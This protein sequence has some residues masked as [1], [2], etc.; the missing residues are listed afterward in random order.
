MKLVLAGAEVNSGI[1]LGICAELV[2]LAG[3]NCVHAD[4]CEGCD[5]QAGQHHVHAA[6]GKGDA[7]DITGAILQTDGQHQNQRGN[8]NIAALGK[9]LA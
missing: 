2:V 6:D 4:T 3:Q 9:K 7:T 5:G 1:A 8:Q